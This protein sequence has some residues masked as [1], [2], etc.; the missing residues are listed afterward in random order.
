MKRFL[1][2]GALFLLAGCAGRHAP[3]RTASPAALFPGQTGP[4]A[5]ATVVLDPGHGGEDSGAHCAGVSEASLSYRL[6]AELAAC[7][8]EQGARVVFTVQ[9]A[10]LHASLSPPESPLVEPRDAVLV[11]TGRPIQSRNSPRP[12]WAR[13]AVGAREWKRQAGSVYFLSL[14]LDD[15]HR[16][17]VRGGLV[18]VDRRRPL[19]RLARTLAAQFARA[20]LGRPGWTLRGVP[21]LT[22]GRF[23]V[24]DPAYNP[25]PESVLLEVATLSNPADRMSALDPAWRQAVADMIM[26]AVLAA[27]EE[28]AHGSDRLLTRTRH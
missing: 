4:L 22:Q 28:A 13:A 16:E 5:G 2:C 26:Q 19:P 14:H 15:F 11:S 20:K 3:P 10:A 8:R 24:L 9:S 18:C 27:H 17:D 12:L 6:A 1:L 25:V 7:L 23:G 21:A